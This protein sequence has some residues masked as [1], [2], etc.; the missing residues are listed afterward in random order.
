MKQTVAVTVATAA[1][2]VVALSPVGGIAHAQ[3]TVGDVAAIEIPTVLVALPPL[4]LLDV[5]EVAIAGSA[6]V[7]LIA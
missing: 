2:V 3:G 5:K 7:A 4:E 6:T 1:L